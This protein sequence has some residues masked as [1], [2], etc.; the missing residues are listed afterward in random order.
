MSNVDFN[1]FEQQPDPFV[2][3]DGSYEFVPVVFTEPAEDESARHDAADPAIDFDATAD[4]DT[5]PPRESNVRLVAFDRGH[6]QRIEV[7][8]R[9]TGGMIGLGATPQPIGVAFRWAPVGD[10]QPD[11]MFIVGSFNDWNPTSHPMQR[12]RDGTWFGWI[13]TAAVGDAYRC[14]IES[15]GRAMQFIDPRAQHVCL[16]Q[17][18]GFVVDRRYRRR[19]GG[20]GPIPL[21]ELIMVQ[22]DHRSPK[23]PNRSPLHSPLDC[24]TR[25]LPRWLDLG[26]NAICLSPQSV[27]PAVPFAIENVD[28]GPESFRRLVDRAHELSLAVLVT[29]TSPIASHGILGSMTGPQEGQLSPGG[30]G[31]TS[32]DLIQASKRIR[33]H[34]L[35]WFD[36][37]QVDGICLSIP[38]TL[39]SIHLDRGNHLGTR[40]DFFSWLNREIKNRHP[41]AITIAMDASG[42]DFVTKPDVEG[43]K[44]FSCQIDAGDSHVSAFSTDVAAIKESINHGYNNDAFQRVIQGP[45]VIDCPARLAW[46]MT[47][48]GAPML[49]GHHD[50]DLTESIERLVRLRRRG[51]TTRGLRGQIVDVFHCDRETKIIAMRRSESGGPGDDVVVV[52]NFSDIARRGYPI[53]MPVAGAWKVRLSSGLP[54]GGAVASQNKNPAETFSPETLAAHKVI[55][56]SQRRD[57]QIASAAVD[58]PAG[59]FVILSQDA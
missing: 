29:V 5:T 4:P 19:R 45:H 9:L 18:S 53:G 22:L 21:S 33:D 13:E 46:L 49:A 39:R 44:G 10:F 30:L 56:T 47:S 6:H 59:G 54:D 17:G 25:S 36:E 52:M 31:R 42:D 2:A 58:I 8:Q 51:Q 28:G 50:R 34:A 3:L 57:H 20:I 12:D 15:N 16:D 37:Y 7:M 26:A 23:F 27:C 11:A 38:Q 14:R 32:G 55:A 41:D 24:V 1:S 48:P 40:R 35:M 43:G